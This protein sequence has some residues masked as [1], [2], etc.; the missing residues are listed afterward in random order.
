MVSRDYPDQ[1]AAVFHEV[2]DHP[3][4]PIAL[5]L[6]PTRLK[7]AGRDI[8]SG[9]PDGPPW[10]L[11]GYTDPPAEVRELLRRYTDTVDRLWP[12]SW[13]LVYADRTVDVFPLPGLS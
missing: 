4:A 5:I 13:A 6:W 7:F 8:F 9:N 10:M 11:C 1:Y 12:E 2:L 3:R